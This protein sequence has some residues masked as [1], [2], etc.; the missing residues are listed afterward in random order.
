M[1]MIIIIMIMMM[2]MMMTM[3]QMVDYEDDVGG[4]HLFDESVALAKYI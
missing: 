4:G 3:V 1:M 2:M